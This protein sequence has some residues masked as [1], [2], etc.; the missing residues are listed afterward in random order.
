MTIEE[1]NQQQSPEMLTICETL[2]KQINKGLPDVESKIWHGGPVWFIDGNPT[3]GYWVRRNKQVGEYV[4]LMFWSGADFAEEG[5][6][7]GTGKFKDAHVEYVHKKEIDAGKVAVW[8]KESQ[9][10]QWDY[11]NLMKTKGVLHKK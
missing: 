9:E 11:K 7:P 10:I 6:Y 2:Q 3:V 1:Y 8:L 5:L 4:R